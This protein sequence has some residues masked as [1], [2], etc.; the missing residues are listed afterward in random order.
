[1]RPSIISVVGKPNKILELEYSNGEIR[2]FDVKPYIEGSWFGEL[3]DDSYFNA[4]HIVNNGRGIEWS[5]GQD[6]AP[7]ELYEL[8]TLRG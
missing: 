3:N 6:I 1:M 5:N 8:S 7:H 4:V 2:L